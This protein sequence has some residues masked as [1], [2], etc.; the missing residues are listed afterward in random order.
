MTQKAKS[1]AVILIVL[2]VVSLVLGVFVFGAFKTEQAKTSALQQELEEVKKRE[3]AAESNLQE[4]KNLI[5]ELQTKL[6]ENIGQIDS[7][8][9][10][11]QEEKA[12]KEE[13]LSQV[14]QL[15]AELEQQKTQRADLENKLAQLQEQA[16]KADA[17]LNALTSQKAE[18]EK[19]LKEI[20]EKSKGVELGKIVVNPE[21]PKAA[22]P[23][24]GKKPVS[25]GLEGKVLVL[26]KDYNFVV[27][28][29]GAKDGIELGNEFSVYHNNKY[30]G[31]AKVEKVH[32]A[33]AAVG[34]ASPGIKDQVSEG[35]KVVLKK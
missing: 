18:L 25:A 24:Q 19:K 12:D 3:Q 30:I 28:N 27:I 20:E 34:F 7:L 1:P 17:Q 11:L 4:S 6:D 2:L 29:L 26:N 23:A 5:S 33:M 15:K 13:A 22:V 21:P 10:N 8:T 16:N 35:D 31:D 32:D 14:M 9:K